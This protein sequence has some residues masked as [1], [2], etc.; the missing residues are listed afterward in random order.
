MCI[1]NKRRNTLKSSYHG[2][3]IATKVHYGNGILLL[4]QINNPARTTN[5]VGVFYL[6]KLY[7]E[8]KLEYSIESVLTS[9]PQCKW[10]AYIS[11]AAT[12]LLELALTCQGVTQHV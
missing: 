4:L 5:K 8:L 10:E 12:E 6:L 11:A 3:A 9:L 1:I 7:Q 2:K